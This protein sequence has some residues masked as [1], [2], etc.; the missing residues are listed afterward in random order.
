MRLFH[1][2]SL[3][4]LDV[5]V[6]V[7]EISSILSDSIIT[8]LYGIGKSG[9]LFKIK[10]PE[11]IVQYLVVEPAVRLHLTKFIPLTNIAGRTPLFR[12][13]LK[14]SRIK[15]VSQHEFERIVTVEVVKGGNEL[16]M[17]IELIP[18]GIIAVLDS[19]HKVLT[20]SEDIKLRDRKVYPGIIYNFPPLLPNP[21]RAGTEEW[22][23]IVKNAQSLGA[24]LVKKLGIPPEVVNEVLDESERKLKTSTLSLD[25]VGRIRKKILVFIESVINKPL[26]VVVKC[27]EGYVSFHPFVPSK[28]PSDCDTIVFPLFNEA[29]DEY[30]RALYAS[31]LKEVEEKRLS[32]ET[33]KLK[34]VV[35]KALKDLDRLRNEYSKVKYII[36]VFERNYNIFEEAWECVKR[37]VKTSGW[38]KVIEVCRN[39]NKINPSEGTFTVVVDEG[40]ITLKITEEI[41]VQY[42]KLRKRYMHLADKVAQAEKYVSEL[43]I[44]LREKSAILDAGARIK[45][46]LKKV[47]WYTSY[48]WIITSN[49]FL[50]IGGKDAQQN[51]KIVRKYLNENDIF[52]HAEVHGAPA[53][54]LKCRGIKP[55][56]RDIY[57]VSVLAASYSKGWKA[58]VGA[59]DVFWVWGEQVSKSAPSGQ[60]L[61]KGAFMV[62]GKRNYV[63]GVPLRLAI[64]VQI[65]D[66]KYYELVV[67]PEDLISKR[68]AKYAVLI[69]G[70]TPQ[71]KVAI[72]IKEE[73]S[74]SDR[75]LKT[76]TVDDIL[77]RIPGPSTLIKLVK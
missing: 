68:A 63:R 56:E 51:E 9:Y 31:T 29:I 43:E 24:G 10:S 13:F 48:H 6:L 26:P 8:N 57:E 46:L 52:I 39:I 66:D 59:L 27:R 34:A 2:R 36:H 64:G 75:R 77:D 44:K 3:T 58:G 72:E 19:K 15:S 42:N 22:L 11:G 17:V 61:P 20:S 35:N 21:R 1:K 33:A 50:A 5:A 60:Y 55:S 25:E 12:R 54:V 7:K 28:L 67:G 62:Y 65:Y 70:G 49:G 18:R 4:T 32:S 38:D 69:P 74:T 40:D 47:E 45:P 73:F 41:H 14:G 71:R 30:Y 37:I 53:F 76:L 23:K 16:K